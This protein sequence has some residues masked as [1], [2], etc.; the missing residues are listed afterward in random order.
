MNTQRRSFFRNGASKEAGPAF[1]FFGRFR[2]F[3]SL[4]L[5]LLIPPSALFLTS[6][7]FSRMFSNDE[8]KMLLLHEEWNVMFETN[9]A[10]MTERS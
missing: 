7:R 9:E 10:N 5:H 1:S 4:N 3:S 8:M 6:L 2:M